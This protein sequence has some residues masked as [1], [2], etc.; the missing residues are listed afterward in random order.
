[1]AITPSEALEPTVARDPLIG[2]LL[3]EYRVLS[4]L[5][6]GGMG[7]V[8]PFESSLAMFAGATFFALMHK[9][10]AGR[11]ESTGHRLWIDTHEPICAGIIAGAAL[12]GIGDVLVKVFV[13]K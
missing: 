11:K 4:R 7:V 3:G 2:A 1:M 9:V 6:E 8:V 12:I 13:L 5:G 10:Y